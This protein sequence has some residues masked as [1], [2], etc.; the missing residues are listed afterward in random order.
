[1]A[2]A[3]ADLVSRLESMN[4]LQLRHELAE[5][6]S[7]AAGDKPHLRRKLLN[8]M[9]DAPTRA[10]ARSLDKKGVKRELQLRGKKG[11]DLQGWCGAPLSRCGQ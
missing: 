3:D 10:W 2:S 4:Y 5:R 6:K 9:T 8:T 11:A 1:M 7:N